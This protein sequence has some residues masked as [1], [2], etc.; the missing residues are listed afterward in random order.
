MDWDGI[1]IWFREE[2]YVFGFIGVLVELGQSSCL[3]NEKSFYGF[4]RVMD[5]ESNWMILY[6]LINQQ[7]VYFTIAAISL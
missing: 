6:F 3:M 4:K 1:R 2:I 7:L 5:I